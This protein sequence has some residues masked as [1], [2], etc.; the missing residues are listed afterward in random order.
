MI[1]I[2]LSIYIY[3]FVSNMCTER[4]HNPFQDQD[5]GGKLF[6]GKP[7]LLRYLQQEYLYTIL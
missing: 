2:K 7:I 1:S 5:G 3:G 6:S 4:K